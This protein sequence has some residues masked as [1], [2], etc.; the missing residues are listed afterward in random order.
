[1]I[2]N[3][4]VVAARSDVFN[5][6]LYNGMKESYEKQI[7]FPEI[8]STGMEIILEYVYT[9]SVKEESLTKYNII[10]AFYAEDYFQLQGLQDFIIKTVENTLEKD[11]AGNYSPELLS[12]IVKTMPLSRRRYFSYFIC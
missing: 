2:E 1:M 9:G 12:K 10:D 4:M 7:V 11:Y 6:L 8:N 3:Y 5:G